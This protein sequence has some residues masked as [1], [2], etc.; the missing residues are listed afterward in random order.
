MKLTISEIYNYDRTAAVIDIQ[1]WFRF[2]S[3][4]KKHKI[5]DT[6]NFFDVIK[7]SRMTNFYKLTPQVVSL[8]DTYCKQRNSSSLTTLC[9]HT[10][11]LNEV[12]SNAL[13]DCG[14]TIA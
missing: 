3:Y 12:N 2:F 11:L 8:Y 14:E 5:Q 13:I 10:L 6:K 9:A 7:Q 1:T 4:V